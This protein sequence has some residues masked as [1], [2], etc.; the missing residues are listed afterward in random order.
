MATKSDAERADEA[1]DVAYMIGFEFR[2]NQWDIDDSAPLITVLEAFALKH[3]E[4][5]DEL[6]E[7]LRAAHE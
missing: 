5:A 1:T 2:L 6:L 4:V 3:P 7:S